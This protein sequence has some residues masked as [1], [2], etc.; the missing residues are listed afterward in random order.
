[1]DR[2]MYLP[3]F[4]TVDKHVLVIAYQINGE[5]VL[6]YLQKNSTI[7][8]TGWCLPNGQRDVSADI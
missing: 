5:L 6:C 8:G 2:E 4:D 1:M 7:M 3:I